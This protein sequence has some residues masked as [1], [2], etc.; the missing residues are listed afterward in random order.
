MVTPPS[1][2]GFHIM[3]IQFYINAKKKTVNGFMTLPFMSSL[4]E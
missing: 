4:C 3:G 1:Q 2:M